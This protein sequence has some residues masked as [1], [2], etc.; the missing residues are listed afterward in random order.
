MDTHAHACTHVH[1]AG[2]EYYLFHLTKKAAEDYESGIHVW[3]VHGYRAQVLTS[4]LS[5]T[6]VRGMC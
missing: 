1:L 5:Y 6:Y 2:I 3:I 4:A